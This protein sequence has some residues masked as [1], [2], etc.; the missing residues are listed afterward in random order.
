ML[1]T[2]AS[3]QRLFS[4]VMHSAMWCYIVYLLFLVLAFASL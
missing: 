1:L 4:F 3:C 2:G